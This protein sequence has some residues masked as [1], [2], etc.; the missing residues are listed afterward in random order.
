MA[1]K[2]ITIDKP[3]LLLVE[4]SHEEKFFHGL[5]RRENIS[6]VQVLPLI[7][8][9]QF[10][11]KIEVLTKVDNFSD[12]ESVGLIRDADESFANT[13]SSLTNA[14]A[15]AGL[16]FPENPMT[17]TNSSP[18]VGIFIPPDNQNSG[19]LEDLCLASVANDPVLNCAQDYMDCLRGVQH[20]EH[21]HKSKA[22]VQVYLAKEP[23]GDVHMGTASEKNI[24]SWDSPAFIPIRTFLKML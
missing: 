6:D 13:F 16:S 14:L 9:Y 20:A 5:L 18:Q 19:S 7:G 3:R 1:S 4:G 8:K 2:S 12:V 23:D 21:P 22:L 11:E 24:W 10:R 15:N 17:F